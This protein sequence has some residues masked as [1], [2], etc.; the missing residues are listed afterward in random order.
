MSE[1][2]FYTPTELLKKY[3]QVADKLRWSRNDLG[4]LVRTGVIYGERVKGKTIIDEQ[5]FLN[6]V[7]FTNSVIESRLIK[8]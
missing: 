2:R 1:K 4:H 8:V 6:A 7:R 5:S 3:P